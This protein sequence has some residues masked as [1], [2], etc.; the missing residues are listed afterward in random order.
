M[1]IELTLHQQRLLDASQEH[2]PQFVD[3]RTQT[4]YVLI[5]NDEYELLRALLEEEKVQ[6]AIHRIARRN[7]IQHANEDI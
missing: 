6:Q 2:P 7:A 1:I 5:R 3:P 4:E